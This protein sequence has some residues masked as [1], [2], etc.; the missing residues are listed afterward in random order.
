MSCSKI[1]LIGLYNYDPTIFDNLTFPAGIVKEVAINEILLKS[2][3]FEIVYPD[4]EFLKSMIEHW[5]KKCYRTFEKWIEAL[6]IEF[7]PLY[8]YDRYEE[9]TDSRSKADSRDITDSRN[10]SNTRNASDIRSHADSNT[11]NDNRENV[12]NA[13]TIAATTSTTNE[14][15]TETKSV[16]AYDSN[17][18]QPKEQDILDRD[19]TTASQ[20][21][22]MTSN[23]TSE[24]GSASEHN[25]G[26]ESGQSSENITGL[27]SGTTN[28]TGSENELSKHDAHLYGNIGVTTSTQMLEDF[29]RVERFNIYEQ[30]AD[31]FITEFCVLVYE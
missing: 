6:S 21:N 27:E 8:N 25:T 12:G 26:N 30:I 14:D 24:S 10:T 31:I 11:K 1:T 16:S 2:G 28:E 29:L 9:Y 13:A 19:I 17:T 23:K 5:G 15:T 3:E 18:Y 4:P 20:D 22:S 7:N